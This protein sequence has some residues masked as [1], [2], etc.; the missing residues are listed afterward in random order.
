MPRKLTRSLSAR[1]S[2]LA[3]ISRPAQTDTD[4]EPEEKPDINKKYLICLQIFILY[5][6]ASTA[7]I[8]KSTYNKKNTKKL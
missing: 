1:V 2:R 8:S 6:K 4:S 7:V 3:T 5:H